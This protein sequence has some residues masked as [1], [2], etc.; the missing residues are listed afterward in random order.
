MDL[1]LV[2]PDKKYLPSICEAIKEYKEH[3]SK[4]EIMA[5]NK[6]IA[7]QNNMD[8]YFV[9]TENDSKGLNLRLGFVAHTVFWLVSDNE[10]IGTFNLRHS[11]SDSLKQI[12]GHIA[13]QIRPSK[14][15]QGYAYKG[16][17]ICLKKAAELGIEQVLITCKEDNFASYGLMCKAMQNFGGKEIEPFIQDGIINNRIWICSKVN[18]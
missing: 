18:L 3:P 15:R 11:L 4:F 10:Y 7:A 16:L 9:S 1:Q 6:M 17:K 5:V 13:Y 8:E 12:G 14:Q 2:K